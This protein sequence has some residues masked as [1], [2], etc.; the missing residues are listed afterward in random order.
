MEI[1]GIK[2]SFRTSWVIA[3][4]AIGLAVF[5][6]YAFKNPAT[7]D[8]LSEVLLVWSMKHPA[9][10]YL[11]GVISGHLF[12]PQRVVEKKTEVETK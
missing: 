10:P 9:V 1:T 2:T 3:A 6:Y 8:T 5:D 4:V 7:G 11:F 12:W